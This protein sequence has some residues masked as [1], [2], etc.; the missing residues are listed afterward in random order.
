MNKIPLYPVHSLILLH[1]SNPIFCEEQFAIE[2]QKKSLIAL[3]L[4][5][6]AMWLVQKTCMILPTRLR[7]KTNSCSLASNSALGSL[8]VYT[9]HHYP[10]DFFLRSDWLFLLLRF[11]FALLQNIV[12]HFSAVTNIRAFRVS[13]SR[14][15]HFA[16][17]E[18]SVRIT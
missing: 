10:C 7:S 16:H 13:I 8:L 2:R 18:I 17:C 12:L 5:Y 15:G 4:L 3:V 14:P 1:D 11:W 9:F 6:V